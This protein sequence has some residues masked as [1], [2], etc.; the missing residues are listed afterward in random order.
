MMREMSESDSKLYPLSEKA[1]VGTV[2]VILFVVV[3]T[4][5]QY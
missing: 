2:I 4:H 5:C 1:K 3:D